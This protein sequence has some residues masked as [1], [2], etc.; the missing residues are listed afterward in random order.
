MGVDR[1]AVDASS[2]VG[3]IVVVESRQGRGLVRHQLAVAVAQGDEIVGVGQGAGQQLALALTEID[4]QRV[5]RV[6]VG[7]TRQGGRQRA[8][9]AAAVDRAGQRVGG[10]VARHPHLAAAPIGTARRDDP[11]F[12]SAAGQRRRRFENDRRVA[13][14]GFGERVDAV[15]GRAEARVKRRGA[16]A[17][18]GDRARHLRCHS[19]DLLGGD[20]QLAVVVFL[21]L[22]DAD[23]R[24]LQSQSGIGQQ[25]D[26][27]RFQQRIAPA[28]LEF[29]GVADIGAA[30]QLQLGRDRGARRIGEFVRL[31]GRIDVQPM[32]IDE[33]LVPHRQHLLVVAVDGVHVFDAEP[34]RALRRVGARQQHRVA[35]ASSFGAEIDEVV[36]AE[37]V[38]PGQV[39]GPRGAVGGERLVAVGDDLQQRTRPDHR[40]Y[41]Q[42]RD[43]LEPAG[44]G[45]LPIEQQRHRE[46]RRLA[47]LAPIGQRAGRVEV[48]GRKAGAVARVGQE[49]GDDLVRARVVREIGAGGA[50][51][52]AGDL[53]LQVRQRR[54]RAQLH[55][56]AGDIT[57]AGIAEHRRVRVGAGEDR[58]GA[59]AVIAGIAVEPDLAETGSDTAV[60]PDPV[61]AGNAVRGAGERYR[62]LAQGERDVDRIAL[63]R[64]FFAAGRAEPLA[65]L[66]AALGAGEAPQLDQV[67][68]YPA[69]AVGERDR[70]A[71][72]TGV[73]TQRI[74]LGAMEGIDERESNY[75]PP[76]PASERAGKLQWPAGWTV[77]IFPD[78]CSFMIGATALTV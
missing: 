44:A 32:E 12:E 73:V 24:L 20:G 68:R 35:A 39:R 16:H 29:V 30:L 48:G 31:D 53:E 66:A 2:K 21:D 1:R 62:P 47:V 38:L 15:A 55:R 70:A 14:A 46:A 63:V 7:M 36:V 41:R 33:T 27:H 77:M 57:G 18:R 37:A 75:T 8:L 56:R 59:L 69:G 11:D 51:L 65:A 61:V 50:R 78:L 25:H 10:V 49:I 5:D 60:R 76:R 6:R 3:E 43:L 54:R 52:E 34:I 72:L 42:L 17:D 9:A 40:R 26:V 19:R 4:R 13:V 67:H 28:E 71:G 74:E 23:G 64:A 45:L 58:I 22:G